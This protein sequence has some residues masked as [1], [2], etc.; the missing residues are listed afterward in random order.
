MMTA[1][2]RPQLVIWTLMVKSPPQA[3]S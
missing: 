3:A 1:G 2:G